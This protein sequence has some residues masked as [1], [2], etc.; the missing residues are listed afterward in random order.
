MVNRA[1]Q[2]HF[3]RGL[4]TTANDFGLM[5]EPP[6]HPELLDWLAHWF[7]HE[8]G[9]SMKKLHRLILTSHT[10][11]QVKGRDPDGNAMDKNSIQKYA[12]EYRRLEVE[13]IRDSMLAVSGRLNPKAFGPAMKPRIPEAALEA[14]TDKAAIWKPSDETEASRRT[15]YAYVKRGLVLPM[16]EVLDL[17]DTVASCQQRQ[18]TTVAPQALSLFN[19]EFVNQQ[20][21]DLA[22]RL[23]REAGTDPEKQLRHAWRLALCREPTPAEL[24]RMQEFLQQEPLE[25][26]CRVLLNLN[27]F[28]YPE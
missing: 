12:P 13:A 18:V 22:A 17:A 10:W 16:L 14:N 3:G 21:R 8:A 7:M 6:S 4:V 26:V 19:G 9:W 5:G 24:A 1:W 28:V 20:A 15:I 2:Q 23:K 27:E 11:R 25:Q